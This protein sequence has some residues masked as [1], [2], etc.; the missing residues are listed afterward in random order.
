V[1]RS[2]GRKYVQFATAHVKLALYGRRALAK[3]A[4]VAPNAVATAGAA[5][6]GSCAA[7]LAA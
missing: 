6:D 2:F 7:T 1:A 3:D 4:G 5:C